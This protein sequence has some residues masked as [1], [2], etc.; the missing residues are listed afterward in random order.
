MIYINETDPHYVSKTI[1][2]IGKSAVMQLMT[3][4]LLN[5]NH[6]INWSCLN[7]SR[8][9]QQANEAAYQLFI[10]IQL[11]SRKIE[12]SSLLSTNLKIMK[13]L[14]CY[15]VEGTSQFQKMY[16]YGRLKIQI[17]LRKYKVV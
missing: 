8:I 5:N 4:H 17:L 14:I 9:Y 10:K 11:I 1:K 13:N 16:D 6:L 3:R 7:L 12:I 2:S 15:G